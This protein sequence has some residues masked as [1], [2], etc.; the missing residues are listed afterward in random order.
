MKVLIGN[1][2]FRRPVG[3]DLERYMLGSGMRFPWS[4][5]KHK[6]ERPRY[7]MFPFFLS[8]TAALLEQDGVDVRVVD[9]VPLNLSDE[10]FTT[11]VA[12]CAPDLLVLEPNSAVIDDVLALVSRLAR[13]RQMQVVLTGT[14][15]SAFAGQLLGDNP[16]VDFIVVGE[17]ERAVQELVRAL[18]A[19]RP[20]DSI[21]GVSHRNAVGEVID[22]GRTNPIEVLDELPP[23]ARH[24]F[25]SYFDPDMSL[26]F[27]GF[28]QK[29]PAFHMHTS[30]GC[31]F[32]CNFCGWVQV[33]YDSGP[34]RFFSPQRVVDEMEMLVKDWGA[35]EI[36]FDDD[37]FSSRPSHVEALCEEL[38]RRG[39]PVAWSA[40]ADAMGLSDKLLEKM[41][42]AGCI[43]IK[44]GIDSADTSVLSETNKPLRLERLES[45]VARARRLG[46][47]THATVVFG[48]SGET[49]ETM[50]ETFDYS[51][52]I[53]IDS[54]QFS[55]ATPI[56]GTTMYRDLEEAGRLTACS[57]DELDGAN[58]SVIQYDD[59]SRSFIE[60]FQATAHSRWLRAKL[61]SPRWALRQLRFLAQLTRNQG[62]SGLRKRLGR[63]M[64]LARGDAVAFTGDQPVRSLRR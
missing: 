14:H 30:R 34:Q 53:D 13:E 10:E 9:A 26:Y 58:T 6:D 42:A 52:R 43:G 39:R 8:Y 23:P 5:L 37:N 22:S 2:V 27:D 63:G 11:R 17:Y 51:C 3:D 50:N 41:A 60:D 62:L 47:K 61:R 15:A 20:V 40:M 31:P 12:E 36:Y 24:L 38:V 18:R 28:C 29:Q 64:S 7:A 46:I 19:G 4:L 32:R 21:P 49:R 56:P 55:I 59:F 57:W 54:I 44:F 33:L 25:P 35:Q 45:I 48:L 1:P 16:D